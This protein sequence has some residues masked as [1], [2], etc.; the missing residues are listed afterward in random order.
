[1]SQDLLESKQNAILIGDSPLPGNIQ[2]KLRN[3]SSSP[4]QQQ[5]FISLVTRNKW[6]D[7]RRKYPNLTEH[8][9]LSVGTV[10]SSIDRR[11]CFSFFKISFKEVDSLS[12]RKHIV[13]RSSALFLKL[14]EKTNERGQ[15]EI[16]SNLI[17]LLKCVVEVQ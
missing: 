6:A 10:S 15:S 11:S 2:T 4:T 17:V 1:M 12:D 13:S 14:W 16:D 7:G 5:Y 9:T 3:S 8:I